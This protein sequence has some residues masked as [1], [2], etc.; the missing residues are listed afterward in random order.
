M[1]TSRHA[2]LW[3]SNLLSGLTNMP[4]YKIWH[5]ECESRDEAQ[6]VKAATPMAAMRKIIFRYYEGDCD[7]G[8]TKVVDS[9]EAGR[10]IATRENSPDYYY[11]EVE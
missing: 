4:T 8:A 11:L 9:R 7:S 2:K 5:G 10:L 3:T 1:P 6:T